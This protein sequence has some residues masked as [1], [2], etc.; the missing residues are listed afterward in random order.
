MKETSDPA[1][2]RSAMQPGATVRDG[3]LGSDARP[4]ERIVRDD[5]GTV[6][7]M[8]LTHRAIAA[9]MREMQKAGERGLGA[10]ITVPPHFEVTVEDARG[11][12]PCPFGHRGTF[13]KENVIVRNLA[14]RREV[15]F[16]ELQRHLIEEH[17]FYQ[18]RGSPYRLEPADLAAVL[19]VTARPDSVQP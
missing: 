3:F 11:T 13:A 5:Q 7:A 4:V 10:K 9:R 17:G 6:E 8:G 18:G 16:S 12:L 15:A 2:I 14:T 1:A 19:E